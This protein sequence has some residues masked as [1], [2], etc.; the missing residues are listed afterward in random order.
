VGRWTRFRRKKRPWG[1]SPRRKGE[2]RGADNG[3][4]PFAASWTR[5]RRYRESCSQI[6]ELE[7]WSHGAPITLACD[8]SAVGTR[9]AS[10]SAELGRLA[11]QGR[12]GDWTQEGLHRRYA[13]R[14]DRQVRTLLGPDNEHEDLVQEVLLAVFSRIGTLRDPACIDAWVAQITLNVLRAALRRRRLR[15]HA[16]WEALPED[17]NP[18]FYVDLDGYQ[19]ARRALRLLDRMPPNE[20]ALLAAFW[21]TPTTIRSIAKEAGC[22]VITVR[23]RLFRAQA[24]FERLARLDPALAARLDVR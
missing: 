9:P 10:L 2:N 17:Q 16:S 8:P 14:I 13:R 7:D 18:T 15:R 4:C 22:S 5:A 11:T 24:R 19:L 23:R 6:F 21:L 20:R 12:G 3:T 1:N